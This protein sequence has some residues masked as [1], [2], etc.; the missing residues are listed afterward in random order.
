MFNWAKP[1]PRPPFS[2]MGHKYCYH[3]ALEA[4]QR[5][6]NLYREKQMLEGLGKWRERRKEKRKERRG[7]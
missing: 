6:A 3:E 4:E 1:V 2:P 7:E 5:A